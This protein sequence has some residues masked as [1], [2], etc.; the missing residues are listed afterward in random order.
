[1]SASNFATQNDTFRR[2]MGNG[3]TY[4]VPPFQRDYSW[5]ENHWEDLWL[6]ILETLREGGEPSHYMG[7]LVLQSIDEK[8]FDVIDGQQRLTTLSLIILAI[9]KN[10][11]RLVKQQIDAEDNQRRQDKIR[12]IYIGD[13]DPITLISHAKLTLN[14]NNDDYFQHYIIPLR[15]PLPKVRFR[16]SEHRL[17]KAFEWFDKSVQGHIKE[18]ENPGIALA[19]IVEGMS[20]RLFFTVITVTNELNAYKVFETLNARGV[21][22]S[23]TDLLKNYLF[24]VIHKNDKHNTKEMDTLEKRWENIVERLGEESLLHFLRTHWNS[25]HAAVR[26]TELFKTIRSRVNRREAVFT[27]LSQME[28]DIDIYLGLTGATENDWSTET[29]KRIQTLK[30]FRVHQPIPLLLSAKHCFSSE[31]FEKLLRA[32]E[33]IAF[34]YNL[35]GNHR[36]GEQ[37]RIY[38]ALANKITSKKITSSAK[39]ILNMHALYPDDQAFKQAFRRKSIRTNRSGDIRIVRYILCKLEEHQTGQELNLESKSFTLEHIFPKKPQDGWEAFASVHRKDRTDHL[40]NMVLLETKE[41]RRMGNAAWSEKQHLLQKS[42]YALAQRVAREYSEWTP[43]Q[44]DVHQE[45]MAKQ[46]TAIWRIPQLS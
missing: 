13:L 11:E 6:D 37:E 20:D 3:L 40:G 41:N 18:E 33:V 19:R 42:R 26:Q 30:M 15:E 4:Q 39:A 16:A 14:R 10:L 2:L 23:T 38:S 46:A 32:C 21:R 17:R 43:D 45:W 44:I 12:Q 22:L 36:T 29:K 31:D 8:A 25:R 27:I 1:M 24:S 35:I 9:L 7:Y 5:E 28:E 34:R